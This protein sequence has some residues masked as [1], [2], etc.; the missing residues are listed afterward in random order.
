MEPSPSNHYLQSHVAALVRSY[1]EL[2]GRQ[3]IE[4]T[5][6]LA[7]M[8]KRVDEA[9]FF[10]ASHGLETDPVL[11]Y[12]N[13]CALELFAM[14]WEEFTQTPSRLTAEAPNR[15]ERE[16]LL[17]SVTEKGFIDD[18]SGVRITA[19]GRRFRIHQATVWNVTDES[20]VKIGQAATFSE[21]DF[22][23]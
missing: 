1:Y 14:N 8:A 22:D 9:P 23:L 11:D 3:L 18:Y 20:G 5:D 19:D 2:T 21:W 15:A 10:V 12:G 13:R 16:R 7:T 17:T 4:Q 6:D